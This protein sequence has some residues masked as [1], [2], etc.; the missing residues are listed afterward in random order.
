MPAGSTG[1]Q[2]SWRKIAITLIG[3][4][5]ESDYRFGVRRRRPE[6]MASRPEQSA[7]SGPVCRRVMRNSAVFRLF[8]QR[9][10]RI[11]LRFRLCGGAR[12]QMLT[13][14]PSKIHLLTGKNTGNLRNSDPEI[15]RLA[16]QVAHS[17]GE[18][19]AFGLNRTGNYQEGIRGLNSLN[20]TPP[21]PF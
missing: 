8:R 3:G 9:Y 15:G 13:V 1:T 11:S 18:S 16:L 6:T 19:L 21:S 14:L 10:G 5:G 17:A 2:G 12:S 7:F 20:R 4:F